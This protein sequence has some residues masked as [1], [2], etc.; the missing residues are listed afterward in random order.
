M[1]AFDKTSVPDGQRKA[2]VPGEQRKAPPNDQ[3]K[4]PPEASG[5]AAATGFVFGSALPKS[6]Q[7][8][9]EGGLVAQPPGE[10]GPV[11]QPPSGF[12][13][14]PNPNPKPTPPPGEGGPVAQPPS[15]FIFV[16]NPKPTP[17][18]SEGCPVAQPPSGFTFDPNPKPAPPPDEG[19]L[20]ASSKRKRGEEDAVVSGA[21]A[22][23]RPR[24][25]RSRYQQLVKEFE[26]AI[27]SDRLVPAVNGKGMACDI[28]SFLPHLKYAAG[29][30][31]KLVGDDQIAHL[32]F[33]IESYTPPGQAGS[34]SYPVLIAA[35]SKSPL[36]SLLCNSSVQACSEV[37][38]AFGQ[39]GHHW[40]RF[41]SQ[42]QG[43]IYGLFKEWPDVR[44]NAGHLQEFD[45]PDLRKPSDVSANI[46]P[47]PFVL[48]LC[49]S[50]S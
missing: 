21:P 41:Q 29:R 47:V 35:L 38:Y 40:G 9:G 26:T 48:L 34:V 24:T 19:G 14:V 31:A 16:P 15:G 50:H 32:F 11:A 33:F 8:S 5:I 12:I 22:P 4:A 6:T 7:P 23:C 1:A 3:R 37:Y 46:L 45:N 28:R 27:D 10:G 49:Y 43:Q 17:P 44:Q 42:G 30:L 39:T 20:S 13:F 2:S 25:R 36:Q 18:P